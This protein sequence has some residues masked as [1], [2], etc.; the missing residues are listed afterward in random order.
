MVDESLKY[1]LPYARK[2][3]NGGRKRGSEFIATFDQITLHIAP[4]INIRVRHCL[5]VNSTF[6][7]LEIRT[8]TNNDYTGKMVACN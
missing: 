3:P 6:L 5:Y 1:L 8:F 4:K 7:D 2:G